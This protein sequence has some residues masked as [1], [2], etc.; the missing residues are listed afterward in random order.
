MNRRDWL[1]LAIGERMEPIQIQ[2]AMF[3]FC[4]ETNISESEAYRFEPYNWGPCSFE[5]YDDLRELRGDGKLEF[6]PTGWGWHSYSLTPL[7]SQEADKI[8]EAA[9]KALLTALNEKRHW[10]TSR[11]FGQL[12]RDVY[13]QY[14]EY[15][16]E[17]LFV[18]RGR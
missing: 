14:P 18:D 15:A 16:T 17:S 4:Q 11:D 2:K 8:R 13:Q 3:K 7:G 10:V 6:V 5:I 1:L 12:L 9:D